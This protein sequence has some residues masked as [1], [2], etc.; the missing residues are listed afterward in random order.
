MAHAPRD[1]NIVVPIEHSVKD[2]IGA[3]AARKHSLLPCPSPSLSA[4][5]SSGSYILPEP[6][7]AD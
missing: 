1:D 2:R 7:E 3:R 5:G 6:A 4:T